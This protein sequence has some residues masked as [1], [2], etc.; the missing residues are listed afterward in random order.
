MRDR[1]ISDRTRRQ[2]IPLPNTAIKAALLIGVKRALIDPKH[3]LHLR[4]RTGSP[5]PG[6]VAPASGRNPE[7]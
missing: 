3:P 6:T 1:C 7:D 4:L 2:S 5:R